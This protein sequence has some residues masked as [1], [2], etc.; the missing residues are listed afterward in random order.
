MACTASDSPPVP[1]TPCS[2]RSFRRPPMKSR[3]PNRYPAGYIIRF[4]SLPWLPS[5][6]PCHWECYPLSPIFHV[7]QPSHQ[8]LIP[9]AYVHLSTKEY[10]EES[11]RR[12]DAQPQGE[13]GGEIGPGRMREVGVQERE[14]V[15][16]R[17]LRGSD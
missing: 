15:R 14:Y 8:A 16:V 10:F 11:T 9:P 5:L 4:S 13:G 1:R 6:G 3:A 7:S 17:Y 12:S 2:R